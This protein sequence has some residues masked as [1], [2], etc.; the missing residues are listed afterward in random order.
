[1]HLH[2]VDK[3]WLLSAGPID[4]QATTAATAQCLAYAYPRVFIVRYSVHITS[5]K[6]IRI[7]MLYMIWDLPGDPTYL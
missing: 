3:I 1:M 4:L 2:K 5:T 6:Y 7:I